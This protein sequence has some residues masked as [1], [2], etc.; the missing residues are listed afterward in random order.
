MVERPHDG[1]T[2]KYYSPPTIAVELIDHGT[3]DSTLSMYKLCSDDALHIRPLA[4]LTQIKKRLPRLQPLR[5]S[6]WSSAGCPQPF[7]QGSLSTASH[8]CGMNVSHRQRKARAVVSA[9]VLRQPVHVE[10]RRIRCRSGQLLQQHHHAICDKVRVRTFRQSLIEV[11]AVRAPPPMA[12]TR[13]FQQSL[14]RRLPRHGV[15][16]FCTWHAQCPAL[17]PLEFLD[18][19]ERRQLLSA[20]QHRRSI[21]CARIPHEEFCSGSVKMCIGTSWVRV[22][23]CFQCPQ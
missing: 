20:Q 12:A 2:K 13:A 5:A 14:L 8:S 9:Q 10:E 3:V 21:R 17:Q 22:E 6:K 16:I 15:H 1:E 7:A 11:A 4:E 23:I 18:A 19:E